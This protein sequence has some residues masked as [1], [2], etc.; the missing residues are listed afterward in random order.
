MEFTSNALETLDL[1]NLRL[2]R[3]TSEENSFPIFHPDDIESVRRVLRSAASMTPDQI[4]HD[5]TRMKKRDGEY[6]WYRSQYKAVFG[7]DGQVTRVI[8]TLTDI[9]A[10]IDREQELRQQAQQDPLTGLYN[11]AG[12][13]LINARLEQISRGVLFMLDL[14]DFKSVN[15]SYGHAAGDKLLIAVARILEETFRTDD[16]VARVGGDEFIALMSGSDNRATAEQKGEEL[17][18]RVTGAK[19]GLIGTNRNMIG[20]RELPAHRTTPDSY[21][22]Q[23]L[24]RRMAD[25]GCTHVVMEASS[26]AL[27]QRRTAGLTFA[28]AVFTNLTQDHLDYHHTMEEYRAAKGLLFD[29]CETAVL[30]LDDEA[31]RWYLEQVE[32]PVFTYSE[33]RAQADLTA[34][35]IRLFPSTWS[36]R[37]SPWESCSASICPSPGGSPSITPCPPCPPGCAWG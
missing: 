31:G 30:N 22:L 9:S 8:G 25:E 4:E 6:N 1:E 14:D 18:E 13:K 26:H 28:A 5:R 32:C 27:V 35:N 11:R 34:R 37:P 16:I 3:V 17:L 20:D 10:Q 21:E 19:V 33:N 36:L 15:D 29:Q 7:P 23:S 2:E 24:L 12:V